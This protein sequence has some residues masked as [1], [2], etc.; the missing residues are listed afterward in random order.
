MPLIAELKARC[1]SFGIDAT[2]GEILRAALL[3]LGR[4][5]DTALEVEMLQSLRADRTFFSRRARHR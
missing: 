2:K 3:V 5:T 1:C 4:H